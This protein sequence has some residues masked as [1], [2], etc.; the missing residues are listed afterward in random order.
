VHEKG[1]NDV[2]VACDG[3]DT[4]GI[5]GHAGNV[6]WSQ[7]GDGLN[8]VPNTDGDGWVHANAGISIS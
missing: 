8:L 2:V 7:I 1:G 5:N 3:T 4:A 6:T